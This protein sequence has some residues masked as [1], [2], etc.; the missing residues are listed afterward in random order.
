[1]RR[2]AAIA[3]VLMGANSPAM[4]SEWVGRWGSPNCA[5][6]AMIIGLSPRGLDLSTFE[7]HCQGVRSKKHPDGYELTAQCS[8]EGR[9]MRVS[10]V[11]RVDANELTF[12]RIRGFDFD[13][14]RFRRCS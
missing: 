13:P 4:A 11:I 12:T 6:D 7:T 2:A 5:R 9:P 3:I 10:F 14:K 8:G 1:M